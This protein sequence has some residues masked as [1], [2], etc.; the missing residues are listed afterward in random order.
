MK[1]AKTWWAKIFVGRRNSDTGRIVPVKRLTDLIQKITDNGGLCV[2]VEPTRFFYKDGNEPGLVVGL[3]N[4]PRFP[5][6]TK[7][8]E[9]Q[10]LCLARLL[11]KVAEQKRLSVQFPNKTIMLQD[12]DAMTGG[13]LLASAER[14]RA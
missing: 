11:L 1:Q 2:T 7:K 3:I 8:L 4:Y 12:E 9:T 10:A 5:L 14:E 6:S 13:P